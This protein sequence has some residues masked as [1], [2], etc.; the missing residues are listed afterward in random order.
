[1]CLE[2]KSIKLWVCQNIIGLLNFA[3]C[4]ELKNITIKD[5]K[6]KILGPLNFVGCTKLENINIQGY[7]SETPG[8]LNLT[9]CYKVQTMSVNAENCLTEIQGLDVMTNLNHLSI[10]DMENVEE[11][12]FPCFRQLQ[13]LMYLELVNCDIRVTP[14]LT[15]CS[16]LT[17]VNIRRCN[18]LSRFPVI[19]YLTA[20]KNLSLV[21]CTGVTEPPLRIVF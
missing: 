4:T 14:D 3:G 10:G 9:G 11:F 12:M 6:S 7:W 1:M 21:R 20:L 5:C 15:N 8:P 2:L 13:S 17:T 16:Q 19:K 18:N